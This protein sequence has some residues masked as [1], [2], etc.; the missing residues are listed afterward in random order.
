MEPYIIVLFEVA[1][2]EQKL[3]PPPDVYKIRL[4]LNG[5]TSSNMQLDL[6]RTFATEA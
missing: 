4:V 3:L 2:A 5:M 1:A 6:T